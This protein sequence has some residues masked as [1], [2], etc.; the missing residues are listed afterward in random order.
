M[1]LLAM[2]AILNKEVCFLLLHICIIKMQLHIFTVALSFSD[3]DLAIYIDFSQPLKQVSHLQ[4][5]V[6]I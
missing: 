3:N 2:D 6:A 5:F 1:T 4:F